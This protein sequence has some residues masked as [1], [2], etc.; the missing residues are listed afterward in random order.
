[1]T[2]HNRNHRI[3]SVTGT[4]RPSRFKRLRVP[5]V[6]V[7]VPCYRY[8]HV[9]GGC[10]ASVLNQRGVDV[11]VLIIDDLSPDDTPEVARR[12]V[13]RDHRVDYRRHSENRGLIATA[14]AGLN[15]ATEDSEYT[16]LLSA[17]DQLVPDSLRRATS[18]MEALPNVGLVYG[19]ARYAHQG[20]PLPGPNGRWL[21]TK[22]WQGMD[23]VRLRCRSG[24]N[25][26]SS[27]EVV[28]RTSVQRDA[29]PY[30][31]ACTHS[32]DLN[33][34]LRIA[35]IADVAHVRGVPQAIY[36]IHSDSMLRSDP[37]VLLSLRERRIA[38]DSFLART[39]LPAA[40][41]EYLRT[42]AARA[43]ARQALWRASRLVDRNLVDGPDR[44]DDLIEFAVDIYPGTMRLREWRGLRI[45]RQIGAGRSRAFVP[46]LVTG[47]AHRARHH[48]AQIQLRA[49]GR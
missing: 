44:V 5:R 20:R 26:I 42:L 19:W 36:R 39:P 13:E 47:A 30:D 48:V 45:R 32:S 29:G 16:V 2:T 17:D 37:S 35:S 15:W 4:R 21:A 23:W 6:R 10:V 46:F 34:W 9:L 49:L 27:P 25:C 41:V 3:S 24:H 18:V 7:I 8:A 1:M 40:E 31:S 11:R 43:L 22:T 12:I 28:V 38:F 14:N 33:M